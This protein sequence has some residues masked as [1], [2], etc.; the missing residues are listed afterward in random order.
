MVVMTSL[1]RG[2]GLFCSHRGAPVSRRLFALAV[3]CGDGR[4]WCSKA[5]VAAWAV[6]QFELLGFVHGAMNTMQQ[7]VPH[8]IHALVFFGWVL[9]VQLTGLAAFT[10]GFF[11][12]RVELERQSQCDVSQRTAFA[13]LLQ[14]CSRPVFLLHVIAT[15][16]LITEARVALLKCSNRGVGCMSSPFVLPKNGSRRSRVAEGCL[17]SKRSWCALVALHLIQVML[18]HSCVP[19]LGMM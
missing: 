5:V 13:G 10:K 17:P 15:A 12:T 6:H 14:Q 18:Q 9:A 19:L 11:L 7:S 16:W 1:S 4:L 3:S 8:P 2:G